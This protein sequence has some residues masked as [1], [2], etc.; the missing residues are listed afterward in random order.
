L[1]DANRTA[2]GILA[3]FGITANP[4][5]LNVL[6]ARLPGGGLRFLIGNDGSAAN[7][8]QQRQYNRVRF[9]FRSQA[10]PDS[11]KINSTPTAILSSLVNT[12]SQQNSSW[13]TIRRFRQLQLRRQAAANASWSVLAAILFSR[14]FVRLRT[15]TFSRRTSSIS[16]LRIQPFAGNE[17]STGTI[18]G[19]LARYHEPI[20]QPVSGAPTIRV[21]GA[22]SACFRQR[23]P[24]SGNHRHTFGETLSVTQGNHPLD[25]AVYRPLSSSFLSR[26]DSIS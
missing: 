8:R 7:I 5:A 18:Y 9:P 3:T 20:R 10:F 21:Q 23:L 2:A 15:H 4:V 6:N 24:Q 11:V 16:T 25:L 1:T 12:I 17:R 26:P 22:D 14:N 19:R 13:R